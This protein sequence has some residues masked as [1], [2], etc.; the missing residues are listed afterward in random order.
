MGCEKTRTAKKGSYKLNLPGRKEAKDMR[1]GNAAFMRKGE[2]KEG[3]VARSIISGRTEPLGEQ[4]GRPYG[5]GRGPHRNLKSQNESRKDEARKGGEQKI[6]RLV[7]GVTS[8]WKLGTSRGGLRLTRRHG[9]G[10]REGKVL[11]RLAVVFEEGQGWVG[12][13]T[14][15]MLKISGKKKR[16]GLRNGRVWR[17][18]SRSKRHKTRKQ[19]GR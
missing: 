17:L 16:K 6:D 9:E 2:E 14:N 1:L 4:L 19:L 10:L 5:G 13:S 7:R 12:N 8:S 11:G 18:G 15:P 3:E